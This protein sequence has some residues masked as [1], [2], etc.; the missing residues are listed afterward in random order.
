MQ[1]ERTLP[2]ERR[3]FRGDIQALRAVA[4]GIVVVYHLF[5][6]HLPGGFVGVDVFFVISGYLITSRILREM[7]THGRVRLGR[8]W[9]RRARRLLPAAVVVILATVLG[10]FLVVPETLW[11]EFGKQA[12]ASLFYVENW[13]LGV[14]AQTYTAA[15]PDSSPYQHFW[16]LSV[17]EQFYI[18][19]P[20]LLTIAL[21]VVRRRAL[22]SRRAAFAII[23]A[24]A[25]ASFVYS[26]WYTHYAPSPAYFVT[27][28]RAW[29]LAAGGLIAFVPVRTVM[30]AVPTF[31]VRWLGV[32]VIAAV[33]LLYTDATPFPSWTAAVP[34]IGAALVIIAG[35]VG[36]APSPNSVVLWRP[37]TATGD[38]SYSLYLWHWPVIV[39]ATTW[40]DRDLAP[41]EKLGVLGVAVALSG[42]SYAYVENRWRRPAVKRHASGSTRPWGLITAAAVSGVVVVSLAS[43]LIVV[44]AHQAAVALANASSKAGA[45]AAAQGDFSTVTD[46]NGP[47]PSP[48]DGN[49]DN[50][51]AAAPGC[52]QMLGPFTGLKTCHFGVSESS[53]KLDVALVGDSHAGS[54]AAGPG[55]DR[56]GR[57]VVADHVRPVG[58]PDHDGRGS[59]IDL[60]GRRVPTVERC[61][62][63]RDR[64]ASIR[65]HRRER[66][67]VHQVRRRSRR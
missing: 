24:I 36:R 31:V 65:P 30:G 49:A 60:M 66:C 67:V 23:A 25:V 64:Q 28:T 19:W 9:S 52:Q 17:E 53:A 3:G 59:G 21:L 6:M 32:A 45:S 44:P 61:D 37:V 8:F 34:V 16:S 47:V 2:T 13:R 41:L 62:D 33:S 10:T 27:T 20:V 56:Q 55:E 50:W 5:P 4:V 51:T 40:V 54:L 15:S 46:A 35:T 43:T 39:L 11:A 18:V 12:I 26:I 22:A 48:V 29:E 57:R 63:E 38:F 14:D 7:T 42:A 58:L 1:S